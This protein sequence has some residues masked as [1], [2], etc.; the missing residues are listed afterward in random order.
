MQ[1]RF[2][3]GG[4]GV[5]ITGLLSTD[6]VRPFSLPT[7]FFKTKKLLE[8]GPRESRNVFHVYH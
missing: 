2:L 6:A 5:V 7:I 8:T 3:P 4:F 1:A